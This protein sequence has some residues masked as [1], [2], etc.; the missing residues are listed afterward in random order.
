VLLKGKND[1]TGGERGT[2]LK[3][4]PT[5]AFKKDAMKSANEQDLVRAVKK[6]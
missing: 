2:T 4:R 6:H 1:G 5:E 3:A